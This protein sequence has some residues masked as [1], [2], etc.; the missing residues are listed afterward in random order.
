MVGVSQNLTIL[1]MLEGQPVPLGF[2]KWHRKHLRMDVVDVLSY[3]GNDPGTRTIMLYMEAVNQ[4][5]EF[6]NVTCEVSRKIPYVLF[7]EVFF[8]Q[9]QDLPQ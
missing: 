2:N 9:K 8:Q 3:Y 6:L 4:G 5:R 1:L 7:E